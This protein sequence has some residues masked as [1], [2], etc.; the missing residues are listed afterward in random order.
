MLA[1][2]SVVAA[3][4][5]GVQRA[6]ELGLG[7]QHDVVPDI[8]SLHLGH[9]TL[10]CLVDLPEIAVEAILHHAVHVP[11]AGRHEEEVALRATALPRT[12]E[13]GHLLQLPPEAVAGVV[14]RHELRAL[15]GPDQLLGRLHVVPEGL[16][17]RL[18]VGV[19]V[20]LG[21]DVD[22][23]RPPP[24]VVVEA[25]VRIIADD[26]PPRDDALGPD[27]RAGQGEGRGVELLRPQRERV[28]D[29][30][31]GA[32]GAGA[33]LLALQRL[34]GVLLVGVRE[35]PVAAHL[36]PFPILLLRRR[37]GEVA[38]VADPGR[39][40]VVVE[41]LEEAELHVHAEILAHLAGRGEL[42]QLIR[43]HGEVRPDVDV[44]LVH[45]AI[46]RHE[47]VPGVSPAV[48]EEHDRGL[49]RPCRARGVHVR[50]HRP[51]LGLRQG[52]AHGVELGRHRDGL[53]R[54]LQLLA[55]R[56][57]LIGTLHDLLCHRRQAAASEQ[58][59]HLLQRCVHAVRPAVRKR[60]LGARVGPP[61]VLDGRRRDAQALARGAF[62]ADPGTD[63]VGHAVEVAHEVGR[64]EDLELGRDH[65]RRLG[66]GLGLQPQAA[67]ACSAPGSSPGSALASSEPAAAH[68]NAARGA[69]A[70]LR[71]GVRGAA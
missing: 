33:H 63:Q 1:S 61:A 45:V 13:L 44:L 47:H 37:L 51:G 42:E 62:V 7:H 25:Q 28:R 16:G 14:V 11:A 40:A 2:P 60:A 20:H 30:A 69:M 39:V 70:L 23:G 38:D 43:S 66:L 49:V 31:P 65:G 29:A 27:V 21:G 41:V 9:K 50:V 34:R 56:R 3:P 59:V 67:E 53:L 32:P 64:R 6:R 10:Q 58:H 68:A 18:R 36:A 12:D 55:L 24:L 46:L 17:V 48:E 5:I 8:L 4:T 19:A 52:R 35:E 71:W 26:L 57:M 54:R 15:G 22:H